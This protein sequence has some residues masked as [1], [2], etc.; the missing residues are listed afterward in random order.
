[1]RLLS[2]HAD[3]SWSAEHV[4]DAPLRQIRMQE[5]RQLWDRAAA[6]DLLSTDL[7][8]VLEAQALLKDP[9]GDA[10]P[11]AAAVPASLAAT[12]TAPAPPASPPPAAVPAPSEPTASSATELQV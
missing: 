1:M 3:T 8:L 6:A 5:A 10:P 4:A 7:A 2:S 12:A 9:D 11:P